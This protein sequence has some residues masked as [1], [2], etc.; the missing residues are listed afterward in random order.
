VSDL[1][2]PL[3]K[4]AVQ[5][6]AP[7]AIAEW[8]ANEARGCGNRA[9]VTN[10]LWLMFTWGL[11]VMVAMLLG[12]FVIQ[13]ALC[14]AVL[15]AFISSRFIEDR[16]PCTV[17]YVETVGD[18]E[19]VDASGHDVI[20]SEEP[21][22]SP[23]VGDI[24]RGSLPDG[25]VT[26]I[27]QGVQIASSIQE[28]KLNANVPENI[29]AAIT[30]RITKKQ[31]SPTLTKDDKRRIGS[32]VKSLITRVYT[33]DAVCKAL[34]GMGCMEEM[35]SRKWTGE[36]FETAIEQA[37]ASMPGAFQLKTS[38]KNEP[39]PS[40]KP[41]RM[42]IADGDVGQVK[43]LA[44]MCVLESITFHRFE[45]R[46]IKHLDKAEAIDRVISELDLSKEYS[47]VEADGSAWDT[48]CNAQIRDMIENVI[49]RHVW[50]HM[51]ELG[52]EDVGFEDDH[53]ETNRKGRLRL[54]HSK[55]KSVATFIIA[56]IRRSGHRGT[57]ILNW[58]MN[59]TLTLASLSD[60]KV[61]KLM[62]ASGRN[63]KDCWG[64][65]RRAAFAH[66]GDDTLYTTSPKL[67]DNEVEDIQAFWTRCGFNMKLYVRERLAE[68]TG[69]KI[70]I[71][72]GRLQAGQ[73]VPDILRAFSN[74]GITTSREALEGDVYKVAASKFAGYSWSFARVPSVARMYERWARAYGWD[75]GPLDREDV[76]RLGY[77]PNHQPVITLGM[78]E[79]S[80]AE[81]EELFR[82]L[83]LLTH[84]EYGDLVN[85]LDSQA[86]DGCFEWASCLQYIE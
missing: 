31:I 62:T 49:I 15:A 29:S 82:N 74:G 61:D 11:F 55:G 73:A 42:I 13:Q 72:D 19:P 36:R 68:F 33:R 71:I 53:D 80:E 83:G 38:V 18:V 51:K 21:L 12:G 4:A 34:E 16:K 3:I 65:D 17:K 14:A 27:A 10:A 46:S 9:R 40:G 1:K 32:V 84:M 76:M 52:F 56:A 75:D 25:T 86:H 50:A 44:T 30:E 35:K 6:L 67:K 2:D 85:S 28:A 70:P 8:Y 43:A 45:K 5:H 60:G 81:E 41:P 26:E 20:V 64:A 54:T 37:L 47:V 63:F 39:L 24:V 69:Y 78:Q 48:C 66:E 77:G 58:V 23:N 59:H 22:G 79:V 7:Y 57:S